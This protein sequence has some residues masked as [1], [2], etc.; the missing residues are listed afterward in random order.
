MKGTLINTQWCLLASTKGL[1]VFYGNVQV[2]NICGAGEMIPLGKCLL[3]SQE[4][5]LDHPDPR[6][7]IQVQ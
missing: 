1:N 5:K 2:K 6:S 4:A 3:Q 7:E